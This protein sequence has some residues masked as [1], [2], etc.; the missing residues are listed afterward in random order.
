M[1]GQIVTFDINKIFEFI[2]KYLI[3]EL[4]KE[5]L[6][7]K[8]ISGGFTMTLGSGYDKEKEEEKSRLHLKKILDLTVNN[9]DFMPRDG[10]TYC[11][12]AFISVAAEFGCY[13][14]DNTML[15]NRIIDIIEQS[16]S[17]FREFR[18]DL[19]A[20]YA[21]RGYFGVA[22]KH[23][24]IHGHI[25]VIAP[26]D[27]EYSGSLKKNVPIVAN[28]GKTNGYMRISLAFPPEGGEPEYYFYGNG[29][30]A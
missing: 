15:A 8:T 22:C 14:F 23:Y 19:A 17:W 6:G 29:G 18:G 27:M 1:D 26:M 12:L 9:K 2:H 10:N 5:K 20:K 21:N 11:N 24:P 25:A 3:G 28:V 7:G 16:N 30:Y 13:D 4:N